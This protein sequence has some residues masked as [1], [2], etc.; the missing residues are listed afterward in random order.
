MS[1]VTEGKLCIECRSNEGCN[2]SGCPLWQFRCVEDVERI[3]E[4]DYEVS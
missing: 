4:T 3:D 1:E 2:D